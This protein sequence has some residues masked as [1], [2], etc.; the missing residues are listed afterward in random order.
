MSLL[1]SLFAP[2]AADSVW[3][4]PAAW[5][6]MGSL[7]AG[8][9]T[10]SGEVITAEKALSLPTYW[11]CASGI[12]ADIAKVPGS[13][14][15]KVSDSE[16][17]RL[18]EHP[19]SLL[20][21]VE[22]N[23]EV[24]A[25]TFRETLTYWALTWGN[26][27][28]EIERDGADR[29]LALW[30]IHPSRVVVKR[31]D[32]GDLRYF[33]REDLDWTPVHPQNMFHVHGLGDG[34]EGLSVLRVAA[35]SL[36][37]AIAAQTYGAAFFGNDTSLGI[38]VSPAPG[39]PTLG[40]KEFGDYKTSL[41]Q[42]RRGADKAHGALVLNTPTK[43]ERI[44]IPPE[45]AQFLET[46]QFQVDEICR[47]FRRSPQKVGHSAR[48]QGWSTLEALQIADVGDCLMPWWRR[49]EDEVKRKLLVGQPGLKFRHFIQALLRGDSK[50]RAEFYA[51]AITNGWMDTDE[52]RE[53]E[54]LNPAKD[55]NAKKLRVQSAM[56]L[57]EK[58]GDAPP[59]PAGRGAAAPPRVEDDPPAAA[60]EAEDPPARKKPAPAEP[61]SRAALDVETVVGA[62]RP[63]FQAAARRIVSKEAK[64]LARETTKRS[65][66]YRAY[67]TWVEDW[68]AGQRIETVTEF[69]EP[70]AVL[71]RLE[72]GGGFIAL[73]RFV[74]AA[75]PNA[76]ARADEVLKGNVEDLVAQLADGVMAAVRG[77]GRPN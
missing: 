74:A 2:K 58:L 59:A 55:K 44:G 68:Y 66:D 28:A 27:Y 64:V 57:L 20:F 73:R 38:V 9:R 17:R 5:T 1:V 61:E 33:V 30:L 62:L 39:S 51:S 10:T 48:A 11:A 63:M 60:E 34:P 72:D 3:N 26:G 70:V 35:E 24:A 36:G 53:L 47:W 67:C 6:P 31:N 22:P 32:A 77:K 43:I 8:R 71:T 21:D 29:P 23:Y 46:R 49:W 45:D 69:G 65:S 76:L 19:V 41:G 7:A 4:R 14:I 15:E 54:D 13:V 50:A 40:D 18:D 16:R 56:V 75:W 12:A 42:A 25:F 52:V 37:L